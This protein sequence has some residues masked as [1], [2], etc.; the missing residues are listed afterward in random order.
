MRCPTCTEVYDSTQQT[1]VCPHPLLDRT[2]SPAG[3]PRLPR[4]AGEGVEEAYRL[5]DRMALY[6]FMGH[7]N[8]VVRQFAKDRSEMLD[9]VEAVLGD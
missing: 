5:Q 6:R 1:V 8:P 2:P 4:E 9:A 3:G 7:A